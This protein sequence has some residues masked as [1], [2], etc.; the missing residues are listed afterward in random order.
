MTMLG[1]VL[2]LLLAFSAVVYAEDAEES[3]ATDILQETEETVTDDT[4]QEAEEC[5][6]TDIS[7][8]EISLQQ[9]VFNY[10][11]RQIKPNVEI[12]GLEKGVDYA[13]VYKNNK[14]PGT[15]H[16]TVTGQGEYC[17]E[18]VLDFII[19]PY[20]PE[21][22]KSVLT[23]HDDVKLTWNSVS[24]ASGYYVYYKRAGNSKYAFY[25]DT[26]E[27]TFKIKDLT[28]HA[29][30]DFKVV[31]YYKS[32]AD[33]K[34]YISPKFSITRIM[35]KKYIPAPEIVQSSLYG[36]D[37]VKV[38]WSKVEGASGYYVYYK[39]ANEKTYTYLGYTTNRY[40]RKSDLKDGTQ[41]TF[42][43]KPR[44]KVNDKYFAGYYGKNT[45][46]YT[47]KKVEA[48]IKR[49]GF[50]R[51]TLNW[52]NI[53]GETGYQ[54]S[55][56]TG[57][58]K[59]N[60]VCTL[61]SSSA[62]ERTSAVQ[63]EKRYYYKVRAY[64]V[65]NGEKIYGPWSDTI[66]YK[67]ELQYYPEV[68][69][70]DKGGKF[71]NIRAEAGQKLYEYDIFQG[72]CTD[73]EYGY[74]ILYNKNIEKCKIAKVNLDD[75]Q[76]VLVSG[77][78]NIHH[79]NDLTYNSKTNKIMAIHLTKKPK[80]IAVINPDTLELE[81][82]IDIEVPVWLPGATLLKMQK[83]K[84][85][86]AIAYDSTS[87]RYVLRIRTQGDYLI[88]DGELNPIEYVTP[89]TKKH[90][91]AIYAGLEIINGYI[92][93]AQASGSSGGYNLIQLHDWEG[94]YA[95]TINIKKKYELESMFNVDGKVYAAFYHSYYYNGKLKRNNY[96][97]KFDF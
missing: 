69:R 16:I 36:H 92:A 75:N 51:I 91:K 84:G 1:I 11:G 44:Y 54:I 6:L 33:S 39:K 59:T 55:R 18:V 46:I 96:I 56:S 34:I 40:Y 3:A 73:G 57:K 82:N 97:Y 24:G 29:T 83:V 21:N 60:I 47:L 41:Y 27:C 67:A 70:M 53:E 88:T 10:T 85:F 7:E 79:G 87:D 62:S 17:G 77:E 12:E 50:T 38:T 58:Y 15:A 63:L 9:S 4:L 72:S 25:G 52:K 23:G 31:S 20:A 30:Y 89:K 13:V 2:V 8:Y 35:T 94:N 76:V 61:N 42:R 65:A 5:E 32:E 81:E 48:N 49:T 19:R 95:G 68:S 26:E 93:S 71:W 86:N 74:Y 22:L 28:D 43:V 90:K 80:R 78:L 64:T 66:S 37:D 14:K 45:S